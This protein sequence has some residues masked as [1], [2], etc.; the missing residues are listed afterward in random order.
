MAAAPTPRPAG[1]KTG[2]L[3]R[4]ESAND[5][6]PRD[7]ALKAEAWATVYQDDISDSKTKTCHAQ[8][9][10]DAKAAG[11][12]K[13]QDQEAKGGF[14]LEHGDAAKGFPGSTYKDKF[15][16]KA[17]DHLSTMRAVGK[18]SYQGNAPKASHFR[19]IEHEGRPE[20]PPRVSNYTCSH[21]A[22]DE[23]D[24]FLRNKARSRGI[25]Q[26]DH[27]ERWR[28]W[29]EKHSGQSKAE[30]EATSASVMPAG[31]RKAKG[32]THVT[33][34]N[35]LGIARLPL[36]DEDVPKPSLTTLSTAPW[37]TARGAPRG[38][39][40]SLE[41]PW[42]RADKIRAEAP[43]GDEVPPSARTEAEQRWVST[44]DVRKPE[45]S[46][47]TALGTQVLKL[48]QAPKAVVTSSTKRP[49]PR[50]VFKD[51]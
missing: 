48:V 5:V 47:S 26:A 8:R 36:F 20:C 28:R 17:E 45:S 43:P 42:Q 1:L 40:Y 46:A 3:G 14:S 50:V 44:T 25:S 39:E 2:Q 30:T 33:V 23:L 21:A 9:L 6:L 24:K 22:E 37:A 12:K 34:T 13:K 4:G 38:H 10:R 7:A 31:L 41:A 27:E 32:L 19:C 51:S 49:S 11:Q 35:G 18:A 16:G 29:Q 15:Q